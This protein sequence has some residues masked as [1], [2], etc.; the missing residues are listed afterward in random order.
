MLQGNKYF[1]AFSV[2]TLWG[3]KRQLFFDNEL[4]SDLVQG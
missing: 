4:L 2:V 3:E 1:S